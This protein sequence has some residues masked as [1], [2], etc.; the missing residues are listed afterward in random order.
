[1]SLAPDYSHFRRW[2]LCRCGCRQSHDACNNLLNLLN[3]LLWLI[4]D[5]H[6]LSLASC[7]Y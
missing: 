1:M 6:L 7:A 4:V 3:N 2:Q 5:S